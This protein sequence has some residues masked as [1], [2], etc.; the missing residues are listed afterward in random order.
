VCYA[1]G[2]KKE[3]IQFMGKYIRIF[4][5]IIAVLGVAILARNNAARAA[6][7]AAESKL[8]LQDGAEPSIAP[9]NDKD[10][11]KE[12]GKDKDKCKGT[13]KPPP[14]LVIPVTGG[15]T[16]A[17][18]G[19]CTMAIAYNI[20]GLSDLLS[21]EV[22]VEKSSSV[23][24]PESDGKIHL[25]GCHILH[26]QSGELM[27]EMSEESGTWTICFAAQPNKT[28]TIYYYLDTGETIIPIWIPLETTVQNGIACASAYTSG[29]YAPAS[30]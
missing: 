4:I 30:K 5:V 27:T 26:Y 6:N 22:P 29:V 1:D 12:K 2:S 15:G 18:G 14:G 24:F 13:V 3:R 20:A 21:L 28:T 8:S 19:V 23:P 16:Y 10:C 11:E 9:A 17:V 25:P 7:P